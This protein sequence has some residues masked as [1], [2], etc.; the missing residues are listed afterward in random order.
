MDSPISFRRPPVV[1]KSQ[2]SFIP[3][4]KRNYWGN[5]PPLTNYPPSWASTPADQRQL[6][7]CPSSGSADIRRDLLQVIEYAANGGR[8]WLQ[9][10][11]NERVPQL[12]IPSAEMSPLFRRFLKTAE[13]ELSSDAF[14]SSWENIWQIDSLKADYSGY[15]DD[16]RGGSWLCAQKLCILHRFLSW[17]EV[18][19]TTLKPSHA[20]YPTLF[21]ISLLAQATDARQYVNRFP[22]ARA[23]R[24]KIKL[25]VGPTNSG[26]TYNALLSLVKANSGFY[27][28]PLRLLAHEVWNRINRGTMGGMDGKGRQCN[29][30]TGEEVRVVDDESCL[31]SCTVEMVGL[32]ASPVDVGV[33]DEIQLLGDPSRGGVWN[34]TVLGSC[35]NELHLCGEDTVVDLIK[36]IADETGDEVEVNYHKRLAPLA[37]AEDTLNQDWSKIRKGDCVVTF[38]RKNVHAI[39]DA[40]QDATPLKCAVAYGGLPPETRAEQAKLF[41]DPDSGYDV[42]VATDAIG[43]GLNLWVARRTSFLCFEKRTDILP[44]CAGSSDESSSARWSITT[45]R[46]SR[47]RRSSNSEVEQDGSDCTETVSPEPWPPFSRPTFL[48]SSRRSAPRTSPSSALESRLTSRTSLKSTVFLGRKPLSRRRVRS[49]RC[50]GAQAATLSL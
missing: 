34:S 14:A 35:A 28:G 50:S 6:D 37:V 32:D 7:C 30:M 2:P 46:T 45:G 20:L 17:A 5:R 11:I 41:N 38:S 13:P 47:S 43:M 48:D 22:N 1:D 18:E 10:F 49:F 29:L 36:R 44:P 39:K 23:V 42:L 19:V 31:T 4:H 12:E 27:A 25:H 9:N 33:V 8:L 3:K 40:I 16:A 15:T 21:H 24:R 26:K